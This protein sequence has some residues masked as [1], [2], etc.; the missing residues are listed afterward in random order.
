MF[1]LLVTRSTI[2]LRAARFQIKRLKPLGH[3]ASFKLA[4]FGPDRTEFM[5]VEILSKV[6]LIYNFCLTCTSRLRVCFT[7]KHK[8]RITSKCLILFQQLAAR[9][10]H[11]VTVRSLPVL[12][13]DSHFFLSA[14][15]RCW[16]VRI[17]CALG[18][19][20]VLTIEYLKG[21][22][23]LFLIFSGVVLVCN[24]PIFHLLLFVVVVAFFF[25]PKG[26]RTENC[27]DFST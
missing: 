26:E 6:V 16:L 24:F 8:Y 18:Q 12:R 4:E 11:H 27:F 25:M 22:L 19:Q 21:G 5:T 7:S 15:R 3:A 23:I 14:I 13:G 9:L 10:L 20:P 17:L 1:D 2:E